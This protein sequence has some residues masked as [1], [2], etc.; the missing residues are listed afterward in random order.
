MG[1]SR[2]DKRCLVALANGASR[3]GSALLHVGYVTVGGDD[4]D[5]IKNSISSDMVGCA[6]A[7]KFQAV[8]AKKTGSFVFFV[9]FFETRRMD[10]VHSE[11]SCRRHPL[12]IEV[13]ESG[14]QVYS[15]IPREA[16]F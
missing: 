13:C 9:F 11:C 7:S 6:D 4:V 10:S 3:A 14:F 12:M 2:A 15:S 1:F 8:S 5:F 16:C